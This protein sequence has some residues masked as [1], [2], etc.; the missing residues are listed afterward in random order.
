MDF[1]YI[2]QWLTRYNASV[3]SRRRMCGVLGLVLFPF[4]I[5]AGWLLVFC[6]A[7][8]FTA[9]GAK[10]HPDIAKSTWIAF[11]FIPVMF[12]GN[13]VTPRP[14]KK[15]GWDH[16]VPDGITGRVVGRYKAIAGVTCWIL[17]TGPRLLNWS[18]TSFRVA[19]EMSQ[20]DVHSCAALL[21]LL[22]SRPN[23]VPVDEIPANLEW[24]NLEATLP[25]LQKIPG[26]LY[27]HGPPEGLSLSTD[28]RNAIRGDKLPE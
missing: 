20:Q 9:N 10:G 3:A 2:K 6:T 15:L 28:L 22:M 25:E 18:I 12:I 13:Y 26:V 7:A 19:R 24:L 23:R 14:E 27:L 5:A 16:G 21:W 1:E 17:F 4:G 8:L 11:G